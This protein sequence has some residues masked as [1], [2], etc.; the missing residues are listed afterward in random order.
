MLWAH[1]HPDRDMIL[2]GLRSAAF[3]LMAAGS[4][5]VPGSVWENRSEHLGM[6]ISKTV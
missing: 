1:C 5:Q 2:R 3:E 4:L 6:A